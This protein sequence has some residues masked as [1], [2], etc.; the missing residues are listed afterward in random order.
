MYF[1]GILC[2]W[3]HKICEEGAGGLIGIVK[4]DCKG[5]DIQSPANI[6]SHCTMTNVL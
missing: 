1:L 5:G 3:G 2:E 6:V 4:Y